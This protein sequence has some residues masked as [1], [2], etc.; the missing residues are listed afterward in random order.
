MIAVVACLPGTLA[1][2]GRIRDAHIGF[3]GIDAVRPLAPVRP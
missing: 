2:F 3:D 1:T